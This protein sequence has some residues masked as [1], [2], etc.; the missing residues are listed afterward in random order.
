[1]NRKCS[2]A[3]INPRSKV[4]SSSSSIDVRCDLIHSDIRPESSFAIEETSI[5]SRKYVLITSISR[6]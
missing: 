4:I 5:V 1:M 2:F 6:S 3:K